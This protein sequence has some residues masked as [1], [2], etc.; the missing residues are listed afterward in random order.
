MGGGVE[1]TVVQALCT[2]VFWIVRVKDGEIRLCGDDGQVTPALHSVDAKYLV[3]PCSVFCALWYVGRRHETQEAENNRVY[4][5][6][7]DGDGYTRDPARCD[8]STA[9]VGTARKYNIT[10]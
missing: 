2:P 9:T 10:V 1:L 6:Y 4:C 8:G 3:Y 5:K 7:G